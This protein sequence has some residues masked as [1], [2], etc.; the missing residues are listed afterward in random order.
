[1]PLFPTAAL[2]L[3]AT[4]VESA[5]AKLRLR[6]KREHGLTWGQTL[7]EWR[8]YGCDDPGTNPMAGCKCA[9]IKD[10]VEPPSAAE[11]EEEKLM[12]LASIA[13]TS[14]FALA[15]SVTCSGGTAGEGSS[16]SN[17]NLKS[18]V[19]ITTLNVVGRTRN[20]QELSDIWGWTDPGTGR[21]FALAGE[22]CGTIV[23]EITDP[24]NPVVLGKLNTH[25]GCSYWFD[26]KVYK[27]HAFIVSEANRHGMQILDLSQLLTV[28]QPTEFVETAHYSDFDDAH[29]V[30][31]NEETG[32]AYAVGTGTCSG[33]LH[34]VNIS[35]PTAPTSA[36]C[37]S[38]DGYTHDVQCVVYKG[39]DAT[40]FGK[41]VSL[42][43]I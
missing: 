33:G 11:R 17:V 12:A 36:G 41:E 25:S 23:V 39:P 26:I 3:F 2:L 27:D 28:T 10:K 15:S 4:F 31:I 43:S 8:Q 6:R 7:P 20:I 1:M 5:S 14:S 13:E 40:Y 16:C 9:Y 19:D 22:Y 34:V 38:A 32:F 42:L 37:F 18:R 35:N 30:A 21:E 29:N 24:V